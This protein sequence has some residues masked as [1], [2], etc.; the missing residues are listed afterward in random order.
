MP[1][2]FQQSASRLRP[3]HLLRALLR[4]A[5]YLPDAT[6]RTYFR[7]YIVSRFK[8]YQPKQNAT[9]SFDVQAVE[10]YRHRSFK[11]RQ[12]AIINERT[13]PLLRKGQKGLN[14]L[15]RANLG[16]IPCLQKVL[17]FAY[18]RM[19]RRKYILLERLL[20]PDHIMDGG[21]L[22]TPIEP[23]QAP[24]QKLYY[25]N[26]RY[27]QYFDAPKA[28]SKT[29]Y[30][31]NISSRY[32]R[33][34]AVLKSQ[35]Q[36]G[37]SI[38]R[39]IK[40]PAMKTPI[41]NVWERPMPIKRAVNNVRRW[42]A[43]TMTRILP[44]L[45]IEEWDN[46][47]A[48]IVGDRKINLVRRRGRASVLSAKPFIEDDFFAHTVEAGIALDKPSRADM[49]AGVQRPHTINPRFMKRM[50]TKL[51]MLCCKVE[52][53]DEQKRWKTIWGEPMKYIKPSLYNV[54][55]D[56]TLFAGVDATGK[57]PKTP[58]KHLL[59][60]S[61]HVQPRNAEGEYMRF[62]FFA[63]RLPEEHPIRRELDEWKRKHVPTILALIKEL[64]LYENASDKV[65][66][67]EEILTR[68]LAHY[69]PSTSTFSEGFARALLLSDPDGTV[70]GMALYFYNY[71]TWTGVPGIYLE[72]LF[73][74]ESYRKKGYGKRL[75][76]E[77]AGEVLKVGGRRLEWSCLDW[78]EPSLKFY[79]S[80]IIGAQR[81]T[82][83]VGLRVDG[84]ALEKLAKS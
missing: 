69:N 2:P 46:I 61:Q 43:E 53:D 65:D 71:S 12:I 10:K 59:E 84:D 75:L 13:R 51:L 70:A 11:R 54:P 82:A 81:K 47:H 77:L 80:E 48:M 72:D 64:A 56:E 83:W 36:K 24:L 9:A 5:S 38:H 41:N 15:R 6:A 27:L 68:T 50:Y 42:Y 66:S 20:T 22:A 31:I 40:R 29:E 17:F 79:E 73:V 58:K 28:A 63:E 55:T 26:K 34:R 14:F 33:L 7:R 62:P 8:A 3:V 16:E 35:C 74:K 30:T 57:I 76:K 52:Y 25:S 18:G 21:A 4:E 49:P 23:G 44:P 1:T 37:I 45:P 67:T 39:G 78:N 19:G 60:K 32:S